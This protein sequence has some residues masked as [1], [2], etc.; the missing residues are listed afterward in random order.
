VVT[1]AHAIAR[2]LPSDHAVHH[3]AGMLKA[4]AQQQ[5]RRNAP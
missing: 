2:L 1:F 3:M 4:L 5:L